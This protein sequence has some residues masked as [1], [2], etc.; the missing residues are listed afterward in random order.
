MES[1][2]GER[3]LIIFQTSFIAVIL[4]PFLYYLLNQ[5]KIFL[6]KWG[7]YT[8]EAVEY[9]FSRS[10]NRSLASSATLR[11]YCRLRLEEDNRFLHVPS[12]SLDIKLD[13][14]SFFITL[15]LDETGANSSPYD[16]RNIT[17]AGNRIRIVGDPGSGKST[18]TKRIFRDCCVQAINREDQS[19]FPFIV[20]L[21]SLEVP[22]N[23]NDAELRG[24][25]LDYLL[26]DACKSNVYR[27]PECFKSY[28]ET[29]GLF[30][31][32]DGLDEVSTTKFPRLRTAINGLSS[33]LAQMGHRNIIALTMRTQFHQEI[34]DA[35][36]DTFGR[37]LFL[38][39]FSPSDIYEFLTRWQFKDMRDK[40]I[41]RI[42]GELTDRPT[43]REMCGNPLVLAMYVAE[44]QAA[45]HLVAPNSRTEFYSK[46]TQELIIN[47]RLQQKGPTPAHSKLREHRERIL[48]RLAYQHLMNEKQPANSL[49]LEDALVIIQQVAKVNRESAIEVFRDV[50]KETGLI[51][52]E[53][54]GQTLRFI[55]LTFCEFLAA[56]EAVEGQRH[57][58]KK[59]VEKHHFLQS[60]FGHAHLRSR[61]LEVIP[62]A[63]GLIKRVDRDEA[64]AEVITLGD[65]QLA[66]RCFLETKQYEN[67]LW[68]PLVSR[69]KQTLLSVP[70]EHWDSKWLRELHL[71]NIVT[72]DSQECST[73]A[74]LKVSHVDLDEFLGALVGQQKASAVKLLSTYATQDAVAVFRLA[75]LSN[76]DLIGDFPDIVVQ[77]C[78]QAPF[79]ALVIEQTLATETPPSIQWIR[80]LAEAALRSRAVSQAIEA[81]NPSQVLTNC[82]QELPQKYYWSFPFGSHHSLRSQLITLAVNHRESNDEQFPALAVLRSVPAPG[83]F[84]RYPLYMFGFLFLFLAISTFIPKQE[85]NLE[86]RSI[87]IAFFILSF[88]FNYNFLGILHF[89]REILMIPSR[90]QRSSSNGK[91][92]PAEPSKWANS[93]RL[94]ASRLQP[95][96]TYGSRRPFKSALERMRQIRGNG[97]TL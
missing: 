50:A 60:D 29:T 13:I 11:R 9:T 92:E 40:N 37:A 86:L 88:I 10:L 43:L 7:A 76:L 32:L 4:T 14:D 71:F 39:P 3:L 61:L 57:G 62:F 55:H 58:F 16:H 42:F 70:E 30:V 66:A 63:L 1:N 28:A 90:H 19:R 69:L 36:R 45:G 47:R 96:F 84:K 79:L 27:M 22:E 5:V 48:G 94:L 51:S 2:L 81:I 8:I 12:T 78:D 24:W 75:E 91:K 77:N 34:K 23:L 95:F 44:D 20:E 65:D 89:Y 54:P 33:C 59:L 74:R 67:R 26:K 83:H 85:T 56:F 31:L 53:R 17:E 93:T 35:F 21:K 49:L 80:A 87:L 97:P 15:C 64:L 46:V 6:K 73:Y 25:L 68:P 38:K 82:I 41:A 52:E 18:L 72:K